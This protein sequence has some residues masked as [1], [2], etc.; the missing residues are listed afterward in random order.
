[1]AAFI[2]ELKY[3]LENR[4]P[5]FVDIKEVEELELNAITVLLAVMVQFKSRGIKFNGNMP[6]RTQVGKLLRE[7]KF[8]EHLNGSYSQ[9]DSYDLPG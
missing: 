6:T 7:S 5:V 8:F 9:K 1:M 4:I 3:C 2:D